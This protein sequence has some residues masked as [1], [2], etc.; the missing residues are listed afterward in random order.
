ARNV[1]TIEEMNKNGFEVIRAKDVIAG[2]V[3]LGSYSSYVVTIDGSELPRGGGGAR[4]MTM[5]VRRK[6]VNW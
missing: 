2:R 5:P 3:D 1:H 4:C 6:K